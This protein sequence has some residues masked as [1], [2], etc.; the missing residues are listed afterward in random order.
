[1]SAQKRD[2]VFVT[3]LCGLALA[4]AFIALGC[5]FVP[6]VEKIAVFVSVPAVLLAI[7]AIGLALLQNTRLFLAALALCLAAVPAAKQNFREWRIVWVESREICSGPGVRIGGLIKLIGSAAMAMDHENAV[8]NQVCN[9]LGKRFT[10]HDCD[11]PI[12]R[13]KCEP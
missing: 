13:I 11:G 4:G 3:V 9:K 8:G 10:D 7:S 5:S 1:V 12:G 6:F 2:S